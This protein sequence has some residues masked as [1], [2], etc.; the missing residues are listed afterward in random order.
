MPRTIRASRRT[1][2]VVSIVD[3]VAGNIVLRGKPAVYRACEFCGLIRAEVDDLIEQ[4]R[5][6]DPEAAFQPFLDTYDQPEN[7]QPCTHYARVIIEAA[8]RIEHGP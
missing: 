5:G 7:A 6:I 2:A 3:T 1:V 8:G 4:M